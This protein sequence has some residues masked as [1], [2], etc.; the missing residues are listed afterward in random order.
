MSAQDLEA[1]NSLVLTVQRRC[2]AE[3]H[4][5]CWCLQRS[6]LEGTLG[7]QTDLEH[8]ISDCFHG[9]VSKSQAETCSVWIITGIKSGVFISI[10]AGTRSSAKTRQMALTSPRN[11]ISKPHG[12]T[13]FTHQDPSFPSQGAQQRSPGNPRPHP[14]HSGQ[15]GAVLSWAGRALGMKTALE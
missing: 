3:S 6:V 8:S 2:R 10:P 5:L 12:N 13:H 7:W 9:L 1:V 15:G 14:T 4:C 11:G